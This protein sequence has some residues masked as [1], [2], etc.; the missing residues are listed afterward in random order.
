[1][2]GRQHRRHAGGDDLGVTLFS[3]IIDLTSL[4]GGTIDNGGTVNGSDQLVVSNGSQ[5]VTLQLDTSGN[6]SGIAWQTSL[7]MR[8]TRRRCSR[9]SSPV[10]VRMATSAE[11]QIE[12]CWRLDEFLPYS[13]LLPHQIRD[14]DQLLHQKPQPRL[15]PHQIPSMS[16]KAARMSGPV[17]YVSGLF[18]S[19]L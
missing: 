4:A 9:A 16:K 6:Y 19:L 2:T 5:T 13:G 8:S 1:M 12:P 10:S 18:Q 15:K 3:D 14:L 17:S 11:Y 7:D